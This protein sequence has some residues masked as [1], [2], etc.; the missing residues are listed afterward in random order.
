MGLLRAHAEKVQ[1][2]R[3]TSD[4]TIRRLPEQKEKTG[5]LEFMVCLLTD[6][7]VAVLFLRMQLG[8][9]C[10]QIGVLEQSSENL[11]RSW[12]SMSRGYGA[13]RMNLDST[14]AAIN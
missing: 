7:S 2:A 12:T 3:C 4:A 9:W 13:L 10:A 6:V 1:K 8:T 14:R 5:K 11:N